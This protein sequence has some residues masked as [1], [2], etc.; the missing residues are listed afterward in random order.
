MVVIIDKMAYEM[1]ILVK[2]CN[3]NVVLCCKKLPVSQKIW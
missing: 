2:S 3:I 1:Y